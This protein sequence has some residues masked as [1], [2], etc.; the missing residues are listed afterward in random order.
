MIGHHNTHTQVHNGSQG[1]SVLEP[2][3]QTPEGGALRNS[4]A[5][6]APGCCTGRVHASDQSPLEC[7]KVARLSAVVAA[8][9]F[10]APPTNL[11]NPAAKG[12]QQKGFSKRCRKKERRVKQVTKINKCDPNKSYRTPF[13]DLFC[14]M[15]RNRAILRPQDARFPSDQQSLASSIQAGKTDCHCGNSLRYPRMRC[16]IASEWRC[17]IL[18]H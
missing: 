6:F 16:K 4:F 2:L 17:T 9:M 15:L 10:A 3:L 18:V 11:F 8:A 13:A 12:V 14:V 5:S 1:R 7:I